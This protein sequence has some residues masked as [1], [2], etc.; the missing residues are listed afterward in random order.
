MRSRR[1]CN[2][3]IANI[4]GPMPIP[5]P[6]W[7]LGDGVE[8]S[9][10]SR[11]N[12]C[13]LKEL[14]FRRW[15]PAHFTPPSNQFRGETRRTGEFRIK[16]PRPVYPIARNRWPRVPAAYTERSR[17]VEGGIGEA[18]SSP[19]QRGGEL[20]AFPSLPHLG[21]DRMPGVR[22]AVEGIRERFH[23]VGVASQQPC[24]AQPVRGPFVPAAPRLRAISTAPS[25][26]QEPTATVT[27][28]STE[29]PRP[30]R[31]SRHPKPHRSTGTPG[32]PSVVER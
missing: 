28:G 2:G 27:P 3:R 10:A 16:G 18:G 31:G 13:V 25:R 7:A 22:H 24:Q 23:L 30:M 5:I 29:Y 12:P 17:P 14:I 9:L 26:Q 19:R 15:D 1:G 21:P 6:R 8:T 32:P 11:W 4:G 20:R